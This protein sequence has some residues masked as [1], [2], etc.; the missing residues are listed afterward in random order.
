MITSMT[1]DRVTCDERGRIVLPYDARKRYGKEFHVA[2]AQ[3][4][5]ILIPVSKDPIHEFE[6]LGR[7]AG[8]AHLS[9]KK[10]KEEGRK[11][12]MKEIEEEHDIR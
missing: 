9:V 6:E 2:Y 12:A 3:G 11:Q 10:I 5:I 7:K 4:E 8:I 1:S